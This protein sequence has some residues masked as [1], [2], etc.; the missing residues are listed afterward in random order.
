[1]S[2]VRV[3][4]SGLIAFIISISSVFTGLI[5]TLTVTRQ[6]SQ[7]EFGMWSLIGSLTAYVF[8]VQPI[9]G[10]WVTREVA[11]DQNSAKT[12]FASNNVMMMLGIIIYFIIAHIIGNQSDADLN[13]LYFAAILIPVNFVRTILSSIGI[14]FKPHI[15]QYGLAIFEISKII[16]GLLLVYYLELGLEGAILTITLA[17]IAS[18][19]I[20]AFYV[21]EKIV[22]NFERDYLKKWLKLFWLPSY[23]QIARIIKNSDIVAFTFLTSSV[24]GLAYWG[25][26]NA[27][28]QAVVH[29]SKIN[30]ALYPK[31]LS[32]GRKEHLEENLTKFLYFAF[33]LAAI[34]ITFAEPGMFVLNPLYQI[35]FPVVIIMVPI[36][37]VRQL[38]SLFESSIMGLEKVDTNEN[39]TFKDYLK[40]KLFYLPTL[41]IIQRTGYIISLVAIMLFLIS[42]E[43][44]EVDL[45][46]YWAVIGLITE[47]PYTV[48]VYKIVRKE[49]SPKIN[50]SSLTK[51]L[52]SSIVV[53]GLVYVLIKEYLIFKESIFEFLPEL[54]AYLSLGVGAYLGITYLLDK[55]TQV[56]FKSVIN[57]FYK[58]REEN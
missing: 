36:I 41:G 30:V 23:P 1:M 4:Y 57:E 18:I 5:F 50:L 7:L 55:K 27:V 47:I 33:P 44:K 20:Q 24:N 11:R 48:Y 25:A 46:I 38:G 9:I 53:F 43:R 35:A 12:A 10:Y 40:S 42:S 13:I 15:V 54:I 17:T 37:F 6:L 39:S 3:T 52:F 32:G 49:F 58:K 22:G 34:S 45:V 29:A 2:N 26:A 28:A 8:V 14:G 31:L 16:L 56:L 19:I 21:K 51:Y